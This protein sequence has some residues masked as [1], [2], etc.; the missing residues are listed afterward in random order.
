[1]R[2]PKKS[3]G[4]EKACPVKSKPLGGSEAWEPH[5]AG[6]ED[7]DEADGHGPSR[8][9]WRVSQRSIQRYAVSEFFQKYFSEAPLPFA[10]KYSLTILNASAYVPPFSHTGQLLP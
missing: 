5:H 6:V 7:G 9:A 4:M 3:R 1:M 8:L 10:A 2:M